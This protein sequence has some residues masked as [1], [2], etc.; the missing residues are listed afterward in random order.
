[1]SRTGGVVGSVG[2][3]DGAN[4]YTAKVFLFHDPD[5]CEGSF[6]GLGPRAVVRQRE[7]LMLI[8]DGG[9]GGCGGGGGGG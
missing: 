5:S 6:R 1:M 8:G 2:V 7:I 4:L 3:G 9:G